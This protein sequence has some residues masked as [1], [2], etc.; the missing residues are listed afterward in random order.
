LELIFSLTSSWA[1]GKPIA[2]GDPVSDDGEHGIIFIALCASIERQFAFVQREW[3]N[4]GND[5]FHGNDKDPITGAN[6]GRGKLVITGAPEDLVNRPTW[7]CAGLKSF[8]ETRGGEY[9]FLP[10]LTALRHI[11][12]GTVETT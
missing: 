5:F 7:I 6:E 3:V 2:Q 4:Y 10:S 11:A 1:Y 8:V 12:A 9:F